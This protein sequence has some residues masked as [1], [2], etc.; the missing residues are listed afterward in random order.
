MIS[1]TGQLVPSRGPFD[2]FDMDCNVKL[3]PGRLTPMPLSHLVKFRLL[4]N[5]HQNFQGPVAKWHRTEPLQISH[6][7]LSGRPY[8]TVT[9]FRNYKNCNVETWEIDVFR[10]PHWDLHTNLELK[11]KKNVFYIKPKCRVSMD[12][13]TKMISANVGYT[14]RSKS[15]TQKIGITYRKVNRWVRPIKSYTSVFNA[16]S[17][18]RH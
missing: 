3:I 15:Y 9:F 16:I 6:V 10:E 11:L 4:E 8:V 2:N 13:S 1:V 18:Q 5:T 12:R 7:C 14:L 17:R